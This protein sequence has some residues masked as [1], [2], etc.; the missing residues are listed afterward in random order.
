MCYT[1]QRATRSVSLVPAAYYA[2]LAADRARHYVRDQ[3]S[4]KY[5]IEFNEAKFI[6]DLQL[7]PDVAGR[8]LYI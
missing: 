1:F 5:P 7:H 6:R 4:P 2:D 3:Y 8:M